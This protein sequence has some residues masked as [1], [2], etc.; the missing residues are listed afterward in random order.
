MSTIERVRVKVGLTKPQMMRLLDRNPDNVMLKPTQALSIFAMSDDE[1]LEKVERRTTGTPSSL[2][3][4]ALEVEEM[5]DRWYAEVMSRLEAIAS[6]SPD[7]FLRT[8]DVA[9]VLGISDF[10]L[11]QLRIRGTVEATQESQRRYVYTLDGVKDL[12][13][14]NSK[15]ITS[16]S[17]KTRGPLTNAFLSWINEEAASEPERELATA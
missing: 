17:K 4:R 15:T 9:R 5:Y 1:L 11:S 6:G 16:N 7:G 14:N 3:R 2:I 12:V 8:R 13:R 10:H